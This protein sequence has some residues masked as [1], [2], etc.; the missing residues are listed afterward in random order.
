M[1][2][3]GKAA[4]VTGT[5]AGIGKGIAQAFARE[6][7]KVVAASRR[8]EDGQP[9]VDG[10]VKAGGTAIFVTC[11]LQKEAAAYTPMGSLLTVE[12]HVLSVNYLLSDPSSKVTGTE[13]HMGGFTA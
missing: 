13:L 12:D 10:I 11:W 4:V 1:R 8:A 2:L 7:A 3:K 6:G 9:V 5:G